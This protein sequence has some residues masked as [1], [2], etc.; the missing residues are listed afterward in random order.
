MIVFNPLGVNIV[1]VVY[2]SVFWK[3][4]YY[5]E[6]LHS[7]CIPNDQLTYY[8]PG[9]LFNLCLH[10]AEVW[11]PAAGG[12]MRFPWQLSATSRATMAVLP[13]PMLPTITTPRLVAGSPLRRQASTSWKS[14]S[15]PVNSQS[16][17]RPGTSKWRGFRLREGVKHTAGEGARRTIVILFANSM[18]GL[19][20]RAR[21]S[22]FTSVV[23][24][25]TTPRILPGHS[26]GRP[27]RDVSLLLIQ[28]GQIFE[29]CRTGGWSERML[30]RV[31]FLH[32][33]MVN[34]WFKK[35]VSRLSMKCPSYST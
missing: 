29:V 21:S 2:N 4:G 9:L 7:H 32:K 17:E 25:T 27:R 11:L 23:L 1:I 18:A 19:L 10:L 14:H 12:S 33:E 24:L 34:N 31:C 30:K 6:L 26:E 20:L 5:D 35:N 13:K 8:Y 22:V 16:E 15:L 3:D 28:I